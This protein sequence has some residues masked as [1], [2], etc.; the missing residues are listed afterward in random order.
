MCDPSI[1]PR[2]GLGLPEEQ[3]AWPM[4]GRAGHGHR[5]GLRGAGGLL[6][7]EKQ[8]EEGLFSSEAGGGIPHRSGHVLHPSADNSLMMKFD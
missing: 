7:P 2:P 3:K 6:P 1:A 8:A 4:G 5:C